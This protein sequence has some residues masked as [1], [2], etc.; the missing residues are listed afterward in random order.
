[1]ESEVTQRV[2]RALIEIQKMPGQ[3]FVLNEITR[4]AVKQNLIRF[5]SGG[6]LRLTELGENFIKNNDNRIQ[7]D[8]PKRRRSLH[9]KCR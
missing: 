8:R 1:M 2:I 9:F 3:Y 5:D 6:Y 4:K 7:I